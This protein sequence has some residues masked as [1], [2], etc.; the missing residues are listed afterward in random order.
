MEIRHSVRY[1][2]TAKNQA[3]LWLRLLVLLCFSTIVAGLCAQQDSLKSIQLKT[4]T[5]VDKS[6]DVFFDQSTYSLGTQLTTADSATLSQMQSK[7]LA[8]YLQEQANAFIK[9]SGNGMFA[10]ISLR[11]TA[12][13]HTAVSWNGIVINPLTMGQV[14]FSQLPLFFFDKLAVHAGGESALYGN[15]AIGGSVLL[16]SS[17]VYEKKWRGLMQHTAGSYNYGFTGAK[18]QGGTEKWQAKTAFIYNQCANDFTIENETFSG[19]ELMKQQNASFHNYGVLQDVSFRLSPKDELLL[20]AWHTYFY[21]EIQPSIQNNFDSA[22]YDNI[23]TRN[24]ILLAT[25]KRN[26]LL[27]WESSVAYINDYQLNIDDVVASEQFLFSAH[28]KTNWRNVSLKTGFSS[29][30]I[31]PQVYAYNSGVQE[32]RADIFALSRWQVNASS[33]ISA[34]LRQAFVSN[35]SVPFTPSVGFESRLWRTLHQS[36]YLRGNSSRSYKV[37]TLNDRYWGG[38][39]NRYLQSEDGF[40]NEIGLSYGIQKPVYELSATT[41]VYY[42]RVHNW[43]MW[44]PRGD[45][46]KPQNIDLVDAKGVDIQLKQSYTLATF[47]ALLLLQYAYT[48]TIVVEGFSDMTPFRGRQMPLMPEHTATMHFTLESP[49]FFVRFSTQ[50]VGERTTSNVFDKMEPYYI[51]NA[52]IG[53]TV[54]WNKQLLSFSVEGNNLFDVV[55]QTVPFKAMPLRNYLVTIN[56]VF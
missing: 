27:A 6:V 50:F 3:I 11:G 15:G 1:F 34:G 17:R 32:F 22:A 51:S 37:P 20:H 28:A 54:K 47:K 35:I 41:A 12:A 43:I 14:D 44:M 39:D 21:R 45:S 30:Y 36:L 53:Y 46:W 7:S 33:K 9:Q 4:L 42:N 38:L 26:T 49:K 24:S 2:S 25:F 48:Q 16:G 56:Y 13:S 52:A 10:G 23:L 31:V 19:T 55:Y 8:Y 5:V 40:A 29:Q 18:V